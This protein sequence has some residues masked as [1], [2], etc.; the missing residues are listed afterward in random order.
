MDFLLSGLRQTEENEHVK[1]AG[2]SPVSGEIIKSSNYKITIVDKYGIQEINVKVIRLDR[3][4]MEFSLNN[5]QYT[6]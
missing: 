6:V 5:H 1:R 3:Q 2:V 4:Y